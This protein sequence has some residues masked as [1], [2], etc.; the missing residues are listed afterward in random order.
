[1]LSIG[2]LSEQVGLPAQTIRYY[3][4]V[5]LLPPPR[6]APNRYRYYDELD[7]RRLRFIRGA[8]ALDFSLDEIREILDL[9]D[10][11]TAPCRVLMAQM[12]RQIEAIDERIAELRRLRTDLTR[13][14][15]EGLRMPE[16][17]QM[18]ACV[19]HLVEGGA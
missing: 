1:M 18:K 7:E 9:R 13:L 4:R 11:G 16:D 5:G 17:V 19:C 6:R 15:A 2:Q 8:R 14:H 12:A 3:E 10:R